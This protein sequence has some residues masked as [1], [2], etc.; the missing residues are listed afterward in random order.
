MSAQPRSGLS[1]SFFLCGFLLV[2]TPC[3]AA[4]TLQPAQG[5]VFINHGQG[6]SSSLDRSRS[7]LAMP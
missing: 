1:S 4:T 3:L 2:A 7:T 5:E 6:T